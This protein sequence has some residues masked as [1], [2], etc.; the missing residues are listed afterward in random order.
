MPRK[1]VSPR[2]RRIVSPKYGPEKNISTATSFPYG[3][4]RLRGEEQRYRQEMFRGKRGENECPPF[5]FQGTR[6]SRAENDSSNGGQGALPTAQHK[7][8]KLKV[9]LT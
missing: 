1:Q 6:R 9:A 5:G 7:R 8:R 2:Q 4:R 3:Q